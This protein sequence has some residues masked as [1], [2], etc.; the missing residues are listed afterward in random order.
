MSAEYKNADLNKIAQDA[1]RDLNTDA[2]KKGHG[3]NAGTDATGIDESVTT[4]FPGSTVEY[5]TGASNNRTIP[6][7]EGGSVNPATGKLYKAGDYAHGGVG[8]P[9]ARLEG[10]AKNHGGEDDVRG[11]TVD[12]ASLRQSGA[13]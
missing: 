11:N 2:A 5:G 8:A 6:E 12:G 1:E 7:S 13:K 4:K 3:S 9:E 10:Y